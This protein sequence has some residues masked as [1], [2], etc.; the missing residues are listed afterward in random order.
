MGTHDGGITVLSPRPQ[1]TANDQVN[2]D[3]VLVHGLNGDAFSTW[4]VE[5]PKRCF[6]P[7]DLLPPLLPNARIMTFGYN[8]N[9]FHDS[10]DG[11]IAEFAEN[12]LAELHAERGDIP[13]HVTRPLIFIC[14]SLGGIV[15]KRALAVAHG[16]PIYRRISEMTRSIIFLATPHRGSDKANWAATAG[17]LLSLVK[18]PNRPRTTALEELQTFSNTLDDYNKDFVDISSE[19]TLVSFYEKK[20]T[21]AMGLIVETWS[22]QMETQNEQV[23]LAVV[24]THS[25]ICKFESEDSREFQS[26]FK[27]LRLLVNKA[28]GSVG[29]QHTSE[30]TRMIENGPVSRKRSIHSNNL[31][32]NGEPDTDMEEEE[33]SAKKRPS[34]GQP[35]PLLWRVPP[36]SSTS[37]FERYLP[38]KKIEA[39]FAQASEKTFGI[40]GIGG[41]GKTQLALKYV[42]QHAKRYSH[43]FWAVAD[44]GLKL[45]TALREMAIELGILD[46]STSDLDKGR[47]TMI[48]WFGENKKWLLVLDNVESFAVLKGFLPLPVSGTVIV[49][50]RTAAL[51]D[52]NIVADS[53]RL[54]TLT[55]SEGKAFLLRR[56]PSQIFH[57]NEKQAAEI[58]VELGGHLLAL[59]TMAA[60]IT[61]SQLSLGK[62]LQY[63]RA[64]RES[65]ILSSDKVLRDPYFDYDLS[66]ATCWHLSMAKLK[67]R[68]SGGLLGIISLL[69]PDSITEDI[70]TDFAEDETAIE[71]CSLLDPATY[72][73]ALIQLRDYALI[74]KESPECPT[75]Q[76]KAS[77]SVHRLIQ[78]AWIRELRDRGELSNAFDDAI[79]CI[80]RAYPHQINGESMAD[81]FPECRALTPHVISLD[82]HYQSICYDRR[83]TVKSTFGRLM[84]G[85]KF[86]SI[87]ADAGWFLYET[88]QWETAKKLFET[89]QTI[90]QET[91]GDSP[92]PLTALIHNNLG[93]VC[94]SRYLPE[95][96]LT[97]F[98][99]ALSIR[100]ECLESDDPEMGNSYSNYGHA[101]IDL[102]R[103][104]EAQ[105]FYKSAI[106]VHERSVT[107][108]FDL[109]E[110]AYSSMGTSMLY[111]NRHQEAEYWIK[112][113]IE[114]HKFFKGPNVFVALTLFGLANLRIKQRRWS[115]A[116]ILVRESLTQRLS[117]LG[118]NARL[119]GV[120]Y[121]HLG[122]IFDKE[123]NIEEAIDALRH[124][125]N[126]FRA[127]AQSHPGLLQRS[128][129]KLSL[130]LERC[131][132]RD[133]ILEVAELR[134]QLSEASKDPRFNQIQMRGIASCAAY[135]NPSQMP[136]PI[137]LARAINAKDN[138][139]ESPR[140]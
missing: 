65:I 106:D 132:D 72:L 9:L 51:V 126:I 62:F 53:L 101:L 115:E 56:I 46:E 29:L 84:F 38:L 70:L 89:G 23:R 17:K 117:I 66:L 41:V 116:E 92:H 134:R 27:Q 111:L 35:A 47:V 39:S 80:R 127:P 1:S 63:Y 128:I 113:A 103:Y 91:F 4:T 20:P 67:E 119:V 104:S 110:G 94:D 13:D 6:W 42:S 121:H 133:S 8:A 52:H 118:P 123:D 122:F 24:A 136:Q 12:L 32:D 98:M 69:D 137:R 108:S 19:Y 129:L 18:S 21:M 82:G 36:F 81:D 37:Y 16:R 96:S 85:E 59:S 57:G 60:Y 26:L 105:R 78:E 22:A 88:G 68:P 99:K 28:V 114:Q 107:P 64:N 87:L 5:K 135:T 54:G 75:A 86:I 109:L 76:S 34:P 130:V 31:I 2:V 100:E 140:I 93:V 124:A 138:K 10:V 77:I 7:G 44:S 97:H 90:C 139:C 48:N 43:V 45:Q 40:H 55:E 112:K 33:S 125:V 49:T 14:H 25:E 30:S 79:L 73:Q 15:V 131:E 50:S 61:D 58:S 120:S 3:I 71:V 83:R 11:R 102:G 74:T 95:D